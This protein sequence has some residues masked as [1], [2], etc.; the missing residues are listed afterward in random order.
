MKRTHQDLF[1]DLV[2]ETVWGL[3]LLL[4]F[5]ILENSPEF[6]EILYNNV[7]RKMDILRGLGVEDFHVN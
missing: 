3:E 1:V 5:D 6:D 7:T 2:D 4:N